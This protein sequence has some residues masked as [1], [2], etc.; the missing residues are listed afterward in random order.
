MLLSF[1]FDFFFF[2]YVSLFAVFF[3]LLT[4]ARLFSIFPCVF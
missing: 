4:V 1:G 3:V 2:V